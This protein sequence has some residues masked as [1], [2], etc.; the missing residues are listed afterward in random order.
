MDGRS[1]VPILQGKSA[2]VYGPEEAVGYELSGCQVVFKGPFKLVR[3]IPPLGD[4]KWRLY[5]L[6]KDPGESFD[7]ADKLPDVVQALKKDYENYAN[8]NR[9][10]PIPDDFDL[11][12]AALRYAMHHYL[13]P[14]L[15]S[16]LPAI[17]MVLMLIVGVF[18]FRRRRKQ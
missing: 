3:N 5:D 8:A 10:L 11:Q 15:K 14:K 7:L 13:L 1:L 4:R 18:A 17:V 12:S 9:V 2:R 6:E 16:A